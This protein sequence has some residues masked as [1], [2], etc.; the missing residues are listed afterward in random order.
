MANTSNLWSTRQLAYAEPMRQN[1]GYFVIDNVKDI[2]GADED[3][4]TWSVRTVSLPVY[5]NEEI[6]LPYG[7]DSA[8]FAGKRTLDAIAVTFVDLKRTNIVSILEAWQEKVYSTQNRAVGD[9][10]DYKKDGKIVQLSPTG[11]TGANSE[12]H[13]PEREWILEGLW[14]QSVNYGSLDL[15]ASGEITIDATFRIDHIR[16]GTGFDFAQEKGSPGT[17]TGTEVATA[18]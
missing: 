7:N 2:G 9:S 15:S 10:V 4:V 5:T 6:E 17:A 18:V 11:A 13:Q 16:P 12:G 3:W 8:W 1:L 14:P